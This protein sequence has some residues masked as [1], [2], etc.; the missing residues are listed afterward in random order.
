ME[1]D[2]MKALAIVAVVMGLGRASPPTLVQGYV[3]NGHSASQA[4]AQL[5]ISLGA[6]PG[7]WRVDGYGVSAADTADSGREKPHRAVSNRG[8]WYVLDVR[9][10]D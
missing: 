6:Q 8:C 4:E 5:L 9:L 2:N 7:K 10:C 1:K 3:V